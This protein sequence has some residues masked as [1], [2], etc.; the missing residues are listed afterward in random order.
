[1]LQNSCWLTT[2]RIALNKDPPAGWVADQSNQILPFVHIQGRWLWKGR[3][4]W[5]LGCILKDAAL[6][7]YCVL[8][9]S[10]CVVLGSR[11]QHGQEEDSSHDHL[12]SE[13]LYQ[14]PQH[15]WGESQCLRLFLPPSKNLT[16]EAWCQWEPSGELHRKPSLTQIC[17][18]FFGI[19]LPASPCL[20][21][22]HPKR[23]QR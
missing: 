20:E 11:W 18:V 17:S 15:H 2:D 9:F 7:V 16:M 21:S 19:D 4:F 5:N 22:L 13:D 6:F 10:C 23:G 14:D 1:M 3:R 12:K 8:H